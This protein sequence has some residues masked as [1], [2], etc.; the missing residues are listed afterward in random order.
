MEET[1]NSYRAA[2]TEDVRARL[3]PDEVEVAVVGA[4][5]TGLTA[6]TMLAGYGARVVVLNGAPGP[7]EHSG[8]GCRIILSQ[9]SLGRIPTQAHEISAASCYDRLYGP[10]VGLRGV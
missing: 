2:T 10:S 7:A 1:N 8:P 9:G 4:G 3:V 6:A 5:P